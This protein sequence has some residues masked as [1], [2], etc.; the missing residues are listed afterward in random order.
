MFLFGSWRVPAGVCT[1]VFVKHDKGATIG[2]AADGNRFA[3]GPADDA[4][5]VLTGMKPEEV[6]SG[7][8][9][10]M[11]PVKKSLRQQKGTK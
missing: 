2:T 3:R 5:I 1:N 6:T 8:M 10:R 9:K 7:N 4:K 11:L